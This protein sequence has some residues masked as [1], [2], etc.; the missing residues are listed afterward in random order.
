VICF[1]SFAL[2]YLPRARVLAETLRAAHRDWTLCAVLVDEPPPDLALPGFDRVVPARD[3]DIPRFRSWMFRHDIVEACTAVK[4]T[5]L[6]RLLEAGADAVVYLDPDIALFHPLAALPSLLDAASVLLTPH[7]LAPNEA[8]G[9]IADNEG[10]A[11]RYGV[12]NL[13]FLAVRGD[14]AGR[15]FARWW[16]ARTRE[17]CFDAPEH[18]LFVDQKYCDLVPALF[19]RIG[20]VRDPGWNVASWNLSRRHLAV[21]TEGDITVNGAPLA[22]YHFSKHGGVGDAMTDRYGGTNPVPHELWRWYARCL[23]SHAAAAPAWHYG[24][25]SDGTPIPQAARRL[26]RQRP[27]LVAHFA[28]PFDA[29]PGG[30]RD[31]F[32]ANAATPAPR[33]ARLSPPAGSRVP[34]T[35][36][37]R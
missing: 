22:F 31:W 20:I 19:E 11:L 16:A 7:Q 18:G 2:N 34:R 24:H 8:A 15:A 26:Y 37:S 33:A 25:Y 35:G 32:A 27:D 30:F 21:T 29:G 4:A 13:G 9:A 1:T 5:M 3:L 28:D 14:A 36:T 6:C 12:F 10:A 23:A 17:A